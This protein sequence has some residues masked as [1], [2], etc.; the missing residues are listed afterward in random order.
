[1]IDISI[2]I[3]SYNSAKWLKHCIE[4]VLAQTHSSVEIIIINDGSTDATEEICKSYLLNNKNIKYISQIN[5]GIGASRNAGLNISKGKYVYFLDSD[6]LIHK[7]LFS[8]CINIAEIFHSDIITFDTKIFSENNLTDSMRYHRSL[9]AK[10]NLT[11]KFVLKEN[12]SRQEFRP[13]VWLYLF[14]RDYLI[15]NL[16]KFREDIIYED[17]AFV[18]EA[19]L[20]S[21]RVV[22]INKTY[23]FHRTHA[24]SIM[25][26]SFTE[27]HIKSSIEALKDIQTIY[28]IS[29]KSKDQIK[30][31]KFYA[32]LPLRYMLENRIFK[33]YLVKEYF[34]FLITNPKLISPLVFK[35]IFKFFLN[36]MSLKKS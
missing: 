4:S 11:G 29:G 21:S 13:V 26:S 19:L 27:Y 8:D 1:M 5:K 12:I 3:P 9:P 6:D 22:Y 16:I 34:S 31:I 18:Y 2:I 14:K 33:K 36:L 7:N 30:L 17:N 15:K 25:A 23:H 20:K 28:Q 32:W 35:E 24:D 10:K